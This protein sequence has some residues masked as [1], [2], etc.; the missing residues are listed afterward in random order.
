MVV[1]IDNHY[2]WKTK[3]LSLRVVS[4][5]G[6]SLNSKVVLEVL[7]LGLHY[8][9]EELRTEASISMPVMVLRSGLNV[10]S[11]VFERMGK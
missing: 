11:P 5:L 9:A 8:E 4:Q 6:P 3:C 10:S 2:P 1:A 7:H